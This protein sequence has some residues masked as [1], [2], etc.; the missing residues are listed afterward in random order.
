[1]A[2]G[3]SSDRVAP[4]HGPP[5]QTRMSRDI[6]GVTEERRMDMVTVQDVEDPFPPT[7]VI[8]V[9]EGQGDFVADAL[10]PRV[11]V[12]PPGAQHS[13]RES[14]PRVAHIARTIGAYRPDVKGRC[15]AG[16]LPFRVNRRRSVRVP[17]ERRPARDGPRGRVSLDVEVSFKC[18]DRS[19]IEYLTATCDPWRSGSGL[20]HF[21]ATL[22]ALVSTTAT[23]DSLSFRPTLSMAT[24]FNRK[25]PSDTRGPCTR[26]AQLKE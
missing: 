20:S 2:R 12:R 4:S 13:K 24:A 10:Q 26:P 23:R 5:S 9:I 11:N 1:M 3:M 16:V 18:S 17:L 19:R 15:A 21:K 6:D 25:R 14:C 22:G 7:G 8:T